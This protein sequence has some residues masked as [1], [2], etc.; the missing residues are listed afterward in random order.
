MSM[1]PPHSKKVSYADYLTWADEPRYEIIDG[2]PYLQAAPSRQ[3]QRIVTQLTG[4]LYTFLKG[5]A[6]EVYTAPFDVRLSAEEDEHEFV[7]VQPDISVVCD[8]KKLDDNGC[9]GAPDLIV[10]VLSPSTW[11]RDRIEKLNQYQKHGVKEYLLIY[12]NEKILEQYVLEKN[13]FYGP[14][15]IYSIEDV[16]CSHV[17]PEIEIPLNTLF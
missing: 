15:N 3:H 7:V 14:P 10:E 13:N 5:K 11:Q 8:D 12:P 1:K 17:L 9:K 2:T 4:E 6:R 16:F